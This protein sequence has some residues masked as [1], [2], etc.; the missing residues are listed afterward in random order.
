MH[1]FYAPVLLSLGTDTHFALFS[2]LLIYAHMIIYKY[3]I[4]TKGTKKFENPFICLVFLSY[5]YLFNRSFI[6]K[7]FFQNKK[8]ALLSL[9]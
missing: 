9:F 5:S 2:L 7:I 6:I 4:S 8:Q 3:V 1:S